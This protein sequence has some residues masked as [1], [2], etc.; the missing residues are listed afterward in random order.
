[1]TL[2][3]P[4]RWLLFAALLV[5]YVVFHTAIAGSGVSV[6]TTDQFIDPDSY[7]R[8]LRVRELNDS[9][10]WYAAPYARANAPFGEVQSWS[11]PFDVLLLLGAWALKPLLGFDQGLYWWGALVS[12]VLHV[13]AAAALA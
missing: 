11:R 6:L 7:W 4:A 8:L 13:A 2:D 9:G 5:L 10:V 12:P 1:M 3:A